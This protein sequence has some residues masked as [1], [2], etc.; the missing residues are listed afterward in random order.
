MQA[1]G[2]SGLE[3]L[4]AQ[5]ANKEREWKDLQ[6]RRINLLEDSLKKAKEE[7]LSLRQQNQKLKEDFQYNL[8]ILDE[9]DREL[10]RYDVITSKAVTVELN[11]QEELSQLRNQVAMLEARD[12]EAR[13]EHLISQSKS[14]QHK[15]QLEE[16]RHFMTGKIQKQMEEHERVKLEWQHRIQELEG[17]LIRHRQEMTAA[18]DKELREREHEFNLKL[19]EMHAVLLSKD[20]KMKLLSKENE[21]Q[22]QA[23]LE[24]NEVLK[25]S[26]EVFKQLQAQLQQ[27][28][29]VIDDVTT[30]KDVR[31]KEF[32]DKLKQMETKL[33]KKEADHMKKNKDMIQALKEKEKQLDARCQAHTEQLQKAE[34]RLV[35]LQ[36]DMEVTSARAHSAQKDMQMAL[37][38][39]DDTIRRLRLEVDTSRTVC[40]SYMSQASSEM[41][42]KD[43]EL[44]SLRE[45][46]QKFRAELERSREE[47]KRYKQDVSA[48]LK[49]EA[50]LEQSQVQLELEWQKR[51]DD[52]KAKHYLANEQLIQDLTQ[53]RD[54]ARAELSE[55]E[56]AL[57]GLTV[58]IPSVEKEQDKGVQGLMSTTDIRASEEIRSLMQQNSMLRDVVSQM[59][60]D[61]ENLSGLRPHPQT[62]LQAS[63]SDA[64]KPFGVPTAISIASATEPPAKHSDISAN[65]APADLSD[66]T[67]ALKQE[68]SLLKAQCR[69][70][71]KKLQ[72]ASGL[73]SQ[74]PAHTSLDKPH[75]HDRETK[76]GLCLEKHSDSTFL[77][78]RVVG[79][80]HANTTDQLQDE[81][82][83]LWRQQQ[84][85]LTSSLM[86]GAA[87]G[88]VESIGRNVTLVHSRLKQAVAYIAHL[89][90]EK[91][92]LIQM[93]NCL[94]ARITTA[95]QD[96]VEEKGDCVPVE[97]GHQHDRLSA[98]EQLQYKLTTQE[99]QYAVRQTACRVS[100]SAGPPVKGDDNLWS[101]GP[102]TSDEPGTSKMSDKSPAVGHLQ[103]S[104][105]VKM[106]SGSE[107]SLPS[108]KEIWEILDRGLSSSFHSEGESE[109][110]RTGATKPGSAGVMVAGTRAPIHRRPPAELQQMKKPSKAPTSPQ[111]N[112]RHEAP[113]KISRIR[114]YNVK[115]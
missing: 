35:K 109:L 89:S 95:G 86:A 4:E 11:R 62:T 52:A 103:N 6:A 90:R 10:E 85:Q 105:E 91:Q 110:N 41:V 78:K 92:Q 7:C 101:R 3:D 16:L 107:D 69:Q 33:K 93:G 44:M 72:G 64:M 2:Y 73:L 24:T 57:R 22:S 84:Q 98:L 79:G 106:Q 42:S 25:A 70:L 26:E 102:N 15:L 27:K 1:D 111:K 40:E 59:R 87:C 8:T 96:S 83:H 29:R 28:E 32:E 114:N 49:R 12:A 113:D 19:D 77:R 9:R 71:E 34:E 63:S 100:E 48:G 31:I 13:Q 5:A 104:L 51:C 68:V 21:I 37:D 67:E 61:M 55:K 36:E 80:P 115:D 94:R 47:I 65:T 108:L 38:E 60:K 45:S 74:V 66:Y 99:L 30:V 112:L 76:T 18:M 56:K 82:L 88:N 75:P 97:E 58:L 54:Q 14:A 53:A 81:N 23:K 20:L 46:N 39:K 17:E 50:D 43:A